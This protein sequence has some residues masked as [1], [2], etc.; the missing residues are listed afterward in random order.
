MVL[1]SKL[2]T[3]LQENIKNEQAQAI[4]TINNFFMILSFKKILI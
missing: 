2:S 3:V 1:A 4:I